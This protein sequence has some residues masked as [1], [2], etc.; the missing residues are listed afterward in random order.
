MCAIGLEVLL[1]MLA[2]PYPPSRRRQYGSALSA[3]LDLG[4]GV[5]TLELHL[6]REARKSNLPNLLFRKKRRARVS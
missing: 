4:A 6:A 1:E 2:A 5:P 3:P